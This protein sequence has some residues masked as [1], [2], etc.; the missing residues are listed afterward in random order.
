MLCRSV[1]PLVG[2]TQLDRMRI[3][4][5]AEPELSRGEPRRAFGVA[6]IRSTASGA[7]WSTPKIIKMNPNFDLS[8][9]VVFEDLESD[10][11]YRYQFGAVYADGEPNSFR[12]SALDWSG[13]DTH[14]TRTASDDADAPRHLVFGSCRYILRT[15]LG[16]MFDSRGDKTFRSVLEQIKQGR[17]V[18]Q[19][20]M[21]G[22]QI[23]ADD[24]NVVLP[25]RHLEEFYR[26]YRESFGQPSI[27]A[28]MSQVPTSMTLDDHEIED[29]WPE[30]ASTRDWVTKYPVAMH[31]YLT[32]QASHSPIF[33]IEDGRLSGVPDRLWYSYRDGCCDIFV[34]DSR[35]ERRY[36][37]DQMLGPR[38]LEALKVWLD[39]GSGRVKIIVTSVPMFP[40]P[41]GKGRDKWSSFPVQRAEILNHVAARDI[42]KVMVLSGDMHCSLS[43]ELVRVAAP[44]TKIISVVSSAFFWPYPHE[45]ISDFS[46]SGPIDGGAAG[47]FEIRALQSAYSGDNFTRL[48]VEPTRV[49]VEVFERKGERVSA[50][51]HL[52]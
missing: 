10:R 12:L 20:L 18:D 28:L 40:D 41:S 13:I 14:E 7:R 44:H 34:T 21:V 17:R 2:A 8:S 4:G 3:F 11:A 1:G 19:M 25:D 6:R 23:Y 49:T 26:R 31:A 45:S 38:Q 47:D 24:L 36:D 16:S 27:R 15:W 43:A 33:D 48:T 52:F 46:T 51:T 32:Y 29:N 37:R 22:D 9:V 39:D 30:H 5:R 50:R 42:R 35:T